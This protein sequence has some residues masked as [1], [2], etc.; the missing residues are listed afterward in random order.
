METT[1]YLP[2]SS[3]DHHLIELS[4][5]RKLPKFCAAYF[6]PMVSKDTAIK[7]ARRCFS[8]SGKENLSFVM[9]MNVRNAYLSLHSRMKNG[10]NTDEYIIHTS[11]VERFNL[12]I[13]GE[14]EVHRS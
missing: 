10:S 3:M 14:I 2:V 11:D 12:N 6:Y 4:G 9:K 1:L 8:K 13:I 7:E 5:D